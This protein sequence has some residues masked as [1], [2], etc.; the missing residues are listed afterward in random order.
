MLDETTMKHLPRFTEEI[1]R[2]SE[3]YGKSVADLNAA[4]YDILS[5]SIAP[6]KAMKVLETNVRAAKGGFT[7][8]AIAVKA[9]VG[10]LNAYGDQA[11]RAGYYTNLMHKIV[12]RG[13]I[14]FEALSS[15][16]GTVSSLAAVLEVD[17][18]ALGAAVATL[19]RA[20]IPVE[21]TMTSIR[22]ILNAFKTPTDE[23]RRA[24]AQLGFTLDETSIK[25]DGL[26]RIM[27][28]LS[29][30]NA[31]QLAALMPNVRG[32]VGFAA[33]MKNATQMGRDYEYMLSNVRADEDALNKAMATSQHQID[34]AT[35]SWEDAK[36]SFGETTLPT[37]T[38]SLHALTAALQGVTKGFRALEQ[39]AP[40]GSEPWY[41]RIA[42]LSDKGDAG[43]FT[44]LTLGR[45]GDPSAVPSPKPG[46][47]LISDMRRIMVESKAIQKAM[48]EGVFQFQGPLPGTEY[49]VEAV[50][51][52]LSYTEELIAKMKREVELAAMSKEERAK[53]LAIDKF[54]DAIQKDIVIGA[55]RSAELTEAERKE[56]ERLA[57]EHHKAAQQATQSTLDITAAYVR[58]YDSIDSRTIASFE[59]RKKF[60]QAEFAEYE[61]TLGKT[62]ELELARQEALTRLTIDQIRSGGEGFGPLE[63][64]SAAVYDMK[65]ELGGLPKLFYDITRTGVQGLTDGLTDAVFEARDLGEALNAVLRDMGKMAFKFGVQNAVL[66]GL[67]GPRR[68]RLQCAGSP[69]RRRC[70]QDSI[71]EADGPSGPVRRGAEAA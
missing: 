1:E 53:S 47:G 12:K 62:T 29:K 2:M 38:D 66:G 57:V 49:K 61:K 20:G 36:R 21:V 41:Y 4:T 32:M 33:G 45:Q 23:A 13:V 6:A 56:V 42:S 52:Q 37:L 34:A 68:A 48:Q 69:R 18:E 55:E 14:D 58:M 16:I 25:G 22:S 10:L 31:R 70:R 65:Q 24:A 71:P 59:A 26:V 28:K 3:Q 17:F 51:Q 11:D 50:K 39:L 9:N 35:Q 46:Q 30:A 60:L 63:G 5:A 64:I 44:P 43:T 8:T 27:Q 40:G 67:G 19:T 54:R 15:S 7:D